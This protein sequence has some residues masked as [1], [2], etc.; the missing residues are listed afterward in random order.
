VLDQIDLIDLDPRFGCLVFVWVAGSR[1]A[2]L[3][4]SL[5]NLEKQRQEPARALVARDLLAR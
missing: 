3:C 1:G 4:A 5:E 2:T